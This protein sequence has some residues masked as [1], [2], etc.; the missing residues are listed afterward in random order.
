[1]GQSENWKTAKPENRT[2][3]ETWTMDNRKMKNWEDETRILTGQLGDRTTG[4]GKMG[5]TGMQKEIEGNF[6]TVQFQ[7][8]GK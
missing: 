2:M 5:E 8:P 4:N 7:R 3:E 1:M 6:G